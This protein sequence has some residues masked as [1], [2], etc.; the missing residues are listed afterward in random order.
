MGVT[1]KPKHAA[2]NAVLAKH[3][4]WSF[5]LGG[6]VHVAISPQVGSLDPAD[7]PE[8]HEDIGKDHLVF[9]DGTR[10]RSPVVEFRGT[11]SAPAGLRIVAPG[12]AADEFVLTPLT[13][14][15][16]QASGQFPD[17][18]GLVPGND[19]HEALFDGMFPR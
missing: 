7:T 8:P 14:A 10:W 12:W 15:S 9:C 5:T 16:A 17:T 4:L 6:R 1:A 13:L 19:E 3:R 18:E 11:S 2:L